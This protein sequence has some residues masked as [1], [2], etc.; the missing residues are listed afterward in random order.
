MS[1]R[2]V[3]FDIGGVLIDW[4][5]AYLYRKLLPDEASVA[6][7]L[8]EVCTSAWNE[9]FDAGMPFADG[10]AD[11]AGR[12]PEKADLIE[13]Y[14]Y[15]WHEML[16]GE[17]PGTARIL[18]RLKTAGVPVHAISNWS[19]ETFPRALERFPFLDAFDVLLV[20]GRE[21]LVKPHSAIF[22]L[23]LERAGVPADDC[24]FID[25][26]PANIAAAAALGFQTEL[27]R[28]AEALE[29]RLAV[30]GLLTKG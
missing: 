11:L 23:F 13:A 18:E 17:V 14:W 9:Q 21:K 6:Q 8:K 4:N 5:P 30:M 29:Q 22:H 12:H 10:I 1:A 16:S 20:S 7:F 24:F 2:V 25:D 19:A 15:R 26:N 27:F 28:T 3:V